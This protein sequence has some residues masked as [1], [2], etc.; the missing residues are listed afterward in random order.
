MQL[1]PNAQKVASC[2]QEHGVSGEVRALP[3]PAR[4]AE[5]AATQLGCEVG[6]IANSLIFAAT[7]DSSAEPEPLLVLTSGAHRVDTGAVAALLAGPDGTAAVRRADP[8]FVRRHTGQPI[9]GVAPLG[10]PHPVRTLVDTWLGGYEVV[11]AAAGHPN[12]VFPTTF[13]ELLRITSGTAAD[14]GAR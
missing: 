2:L 10:H 4:T 3:E 11:W 8:D 6:A 14:V 1:H 7:T 13:A 12:T 9:G 5:A